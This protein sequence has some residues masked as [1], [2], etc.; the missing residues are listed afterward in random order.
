MT[1]TQPAPHGTHYFDSQADDARCTRGDGCTITR[2]ERVA[3]LAARA[4]AAKARRRP[5]ARK[6][7]TPGSIEA[8]EADNER[9]RARRARTGR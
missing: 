9:R 1:T 4:D 8:R 7:T 5:E 6:D 3:Y 2:A